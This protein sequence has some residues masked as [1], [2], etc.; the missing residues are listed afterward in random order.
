ML[1]EVLRV[2]HGGHHGHRNGTI[3]AML[4]E[5]LRV[6]HGGHHGYRNGTIL[7]ILNLHVAPS[8]FGSIGFTVQE[9]MWFKLLLSLPPSSILELKNDFNNFKFL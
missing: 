9:Q 4:F 6:R 7:A 2:R 8:S 3:L 5:V 1:F